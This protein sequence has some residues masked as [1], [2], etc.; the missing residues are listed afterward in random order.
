M[1]LL[2]KVFKYKDKRTKCA[3]YISAFVFSNKRRAKLQRKIVKKVRIC[4]CTFKFTGCLNKFWMK[5]FLKCQSHKILIL[6]MLPIWDFFEI[7]NIVEL[8]P[9]KQLVEVRPTALPASIPWLAS[10]SPCLSVCSTL[11]TGT[12]TFM[13]KNPLTGTIT[14]SKVSL[15]YFLFIFSAMYSSWGLLSKFFQ[16][17]A[18]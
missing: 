3:R 18:R 6:P 10:C 4:K 7:R 2:D 15:G 14:C 16:N 9:W 12:H 13:P 5:T 17:L 8:V 1:A 11:P